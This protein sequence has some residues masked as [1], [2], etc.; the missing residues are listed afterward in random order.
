MLRLL[1]V[2]AE[3]GIAP[4]A[5]LCRQLEEQTLLA[6]SRGGVVPPSRI[7]TEQRHRRAHTGVG[8]E[9]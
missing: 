1:G 9:D 6:L 7:D 5:A 3:R 8:R 4:S 2:A